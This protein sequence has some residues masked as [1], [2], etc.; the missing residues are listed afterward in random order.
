[1]RRSWM[2][3]LL[4]FLAA[5][6]AAQ[7]QEVPAEGEK[8]E[9][10]AQ[11]E[12]PFA[13]FEKLVEGAEHIEGFID[14][15]RKE[16]KLYL[17]V[18]KEMLGE[19]FLMDTRVAQ[20]IGAAGLYG[21]TTPSYFEMDLMAIE[22]HD[23]K[24]YLVQRPQRF[25]AEDD[26]RAQQAVALT[27]GSS[28]VETAEIAATRPDSALVI[29][30]ADWFVSDLSGISRYVRSA[31]STSPGKPGTANF[32]KD[33]SYLENAKGFEDNITVR[34]R[35]TYRPGKPVG[36][37]SV[38]DG[39]YIS[40]SMAYSFIRL[41]EEPMERRIADERV[42]NFWT[43]HKDF[44]SEESTFFR[45]LVNRWRLEP[46]ERVGDKWRPEKPIT[47][48]VD[49]N[50]PDEYR[51]WFKAGINAW[52]AAFEAAGW[53][54][55]IQGLDLPE[56]A[57]PDNVEY[58]TLR[59]NTSDRRGY[60]AIGPSKVD[61]RTGEILDADI[62]FEADMFRG[63]RNIWK[64]L[65]NPVTAAEA[66]EMTLGVGAYES[67]TGRSL[68]VELP[69][70]SSA[71]QA[72]GTVA[73]ALLTAKGV[74]EPG[75]PI[76]DELL[77]QYTMWVVMHEVGHSLGLQHNFRSS[78][79]TPLDKL[80]DTA[81]TR[82]NG[83]FSSVM[84]YPTVNLNPNG[85]NSEYYTHAPGSY[86]RWAISFA[87]TQ[88]Q[89]DADEI[90]R[91]VSKLE[92]MFGTESSG[93][94]ALDPSINTYDLSADPLQWGIDRTAM[95]RDLLRELP[96][97]VLTDNSRYADLVSAYSQLMNDYARAVAPA[98]KYI[99]GQY[100]NRD[101]VGDGRPPFVIVPKAE[102][103]KALRMIVDRVFAPNA[104]ELDDEILRMF[105]SDRWTH[106][107]NNGT[108]F[109][110]RL[111]FPYH[112]RMLSF[113]TSV[114]GQL[115]HPWR[116]SRIRDGE[117]KFGQ[118]RVVTI[119]ELMSSLTDAIWS[120]VGSGN[121]NA[122]RRDLQRAYLDAMTGILVDPP[123]RM[124][125]DAR[126]VARWQLGELAG[127]IESA[128]SPTLDAYTQAHLAEAAARIGKALEAGLEAEGN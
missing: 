32:D 86:D 85:P 45:R 46:G 57:D 11:E 59:W 54:D 25:G 92:H 126:S 79:S 1:M 66:F 18:P 29:D 110:G 67:T 76:P 87:Y 95:V 125:A 22:K 99:G 9:E 111:D 3:A 113:Q 128:Q 21:G 115:L 103:E 51:D 24:L 120:E 50:V 30:A 61:P 118:N 77:G 97:I 123:D 116:L 117:T 89:E 41:P 81:F 44:S 34:A 112:E 6:I 53:V 4:L 10:E 65:V 71:L 33:R 84:E 91:E 20:G 49:H 55:A 124:P 12:G 13:D 107:G 100:L 114:L 72:Q 23:E 80:Y 70:F 2:L 8:E 119:P 105:G 106:W 101:R 121:V 42:G 109:N 60:G 96:E 127:R 75:E 68:G 94:G 74:I 64:N 5:P 36:F 52:N 47:Y 108:S 83:V 27:I 82:E 14:M 102:Q 48:Y 69:G 28:V 78:A 58:A 31:A 93:G 38:P 122:G 62:L 40:L 88:E 73:A 104:L 39:R 56:G 90:A 35:V 98:V 43:V 26:W 16:G 19:G 17:A 15:Y 63:F 7:E 37:S